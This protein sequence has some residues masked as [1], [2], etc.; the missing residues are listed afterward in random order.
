LLNHQSGGF[1]S[2][3]F[4]KDTGFTYLLL[5][6][7]LFAVQAA[8]G[9]NDNPTAPNP[10][11]NSLATIK[12]FGPWGVTANCKVRA[13]YS[14]TASFKGQQQQQ[15]PPPLLRHCRCRSAAAAALLPSPSLLYAHC[16][17]QEGPVTRKASSRM[18]TDPLACT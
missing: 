1:L 10:A 13:G 14:R 2:Q 8:S 9:P 6:L 3:D 18:A 12:S 4:A 17:C 16:Q 15:R 5:L 7:L 11:W